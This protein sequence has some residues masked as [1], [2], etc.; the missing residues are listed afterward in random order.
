MNNTTLYMYIADFSGILRK[1]TEICRILHSMGPCIYLYPHTRNSVTC[2]VKGSGEGFS[3]IYVIAAD[4]VPAVAHVIPVPAFG[5]G[6]GQ[7]DVVHQPVIAVQIVADVIQLLDRANRDK[8]LGFFAR[9]LNGRRHSR[10]VEY[11]HGRCQHGG[12]QAIF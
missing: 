11:Q 5:R 3:A 7:V 10:Q 2:P 4:G 6:F 12:H 9:N 1:Q 8:L